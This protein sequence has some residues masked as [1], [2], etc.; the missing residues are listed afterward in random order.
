MIPM[1]V[2]QVNAR[3]NRLA[4]FLLLAA[5]SLQANDDADEKAEAGF[6][7][8]LPAPLSDNW[9]KS[10]L[11]T[12][13]ADVELFGGGISTHAEYTMDD[14][15]CIIT[16]TGDAPM[17]QG[18]SM[19]FSN[20]AAAG[21]TGARVSH[22]GSESIVITQEGEVQALTGNYLTQYQ[23]S[24]SQEHKLAYVAI[25]NFDGLRQ[26][27]SANSVA[28]ET[29]LPVTEAGLEWDVAFGGTA[30]DWAYA[31]TGTADGGLCTAGRTA[32]KGAGLEDAWI[33]RVDGHGKLLWDRT[34]G[35]S[36]IDRARAVIETRDGVLVVAGATESKGAGEFDAWVLKLDP[37]GELIWER[38]FGG[39][40]T[41]WASAV[42]E[43]QDGGLAVAAYT[44]TTADDPFD[45][46][47]FKL[48][49]DGELLW[50]HRLGGPKTDWANAITET[51][52]ES[53]VVVGHTESRGAGGADWWVIKLSADGEPQWERTFGG[54]ARDYASAVTAATDGGIVLAGLTESVGAGG[55][56]SRI[57]K[58]D[59]AGNILW[60]RIVGG[61]GDD[62]ARAVIETSDGG[63]AVAGYTISTG[64]GLYDVWALRL[65]AQGTLLWERTFGGTANEWARALVETQDGGLAIAGD[66]W[67]KGAGQSDVWVI[68]VAGD[69]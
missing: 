45:F 27:H 48:D 68:K 35:G 22:V 1:K 23:G 69:R 4:I 25:T 51:T 57:I 9:T 56:D 7:T 2:V 21:L 33:V 63:H 16:I 17:M 64:A 5:G 15:T 20:P 32:S 47:V 67:S 54:K 52:D 49:T 66:T 31:M 44:Q 8:F 19:N 29:Q 50:E 55:V 40:A 38:H 28:A 34:F 36:A 24:C 60:D 65:D 61:A 62:W 41:D 26:Y 53:L 43:T 11:I 14:A 13:P 30:K 58:L 46:W 18:W 37:R 10:R 12:K 42:V 59:P 6:G 3:K 39:R